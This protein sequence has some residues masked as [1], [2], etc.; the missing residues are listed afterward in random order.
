VF[1]PEHSKASEFDLSFRDQA[2][3]EVIE[4]GLNDSAG[5]IQGKVEV[6]GDPFRQVVFNHGF[7][8]YRST[9]ESKRPGRRCL[10][11]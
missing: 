1:D 8:E 9:S 2:D 6:G 10:W 11:R 4:D 7:S 5:E 3:Y